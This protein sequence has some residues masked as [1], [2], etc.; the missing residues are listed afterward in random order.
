VHVECHA[1]LGWVLGNVGGA[2]ERLRR[3]CVAGAVLPDLDGL[4][5]LGGAIA[6]GNYHHT[7]GHNVFLGVLF[8]AVA[9][10]HC[11]SWRALV[12]SSLCF[13]S[14]LLADAWLSGWLLHLFWPLSGRGYLFPNAVDLAH[15]VNLWLV[16]AALA[17]IVALAVAYKRTPLELLWPGLDRLVMSALSPR[18]LECA[19][20]GGMANQTCASC[21]QAVCWR[22]AAVRKQWRI[23]CSQCA[24]R[25]PE[26]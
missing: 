4:S 19:T 17:G 14:H 22:H 24:S 9:T 20:C 12:L 16:Y 13:A 10:W 3:Y 26:Q 8:T 18:R 11:R 5:Y 7:F 21:G 1:I 15:P 2:D 23:E 25:P 6:Y